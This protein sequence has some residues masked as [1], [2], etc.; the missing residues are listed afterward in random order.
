MYKIL[1]VEVFGPF[2]SIYEVNVDF[3]SK[4][5]IYKR[6]EAMFLDVEKFNINLDEIKLNDFA[7][8]LDKYKIYDWQDFYKD[9][10]LDKGYKWGVKLLTSETNKVSKGIVTVP[11]DW[12]NLCKDLTALL[13]KKFA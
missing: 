9:P 10:N 13:G 12:D 1:E 5:A 6:Q 7:A 8:K 2:G 3:E 11:E 4:K